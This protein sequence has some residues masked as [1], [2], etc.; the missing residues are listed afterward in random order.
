MTSILTKALL[1]TVEENRVSSAYLLLG[2][3]AQNL[4][5]QALLFA[6]RLNCIQSSICEDCSS[7]KKIE[8]MVHPDV[9]VLTN[10]EESIKIESLRELQRKLQFK[11]YEGKW[12]VVIIENAHALSTPASNCL[13]KVLEEPPQLT[14]FVLL[15]T[16]IEHLLPTIVSRCHIVRLTTASS[17]ATFVPFPEFLNDLLSLPDKV[18]LILDLAKKIAQSDELFSQCIEILTAWYHDLL[19]YKRGITPIQSPLKEKTVLGQ[20]M[21]RKWEL[22]KL[23]DKFQSILEAKKQLKFQVNRELLAESLLLNLSQ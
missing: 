16:H 21:A 18:P 11:P 3:D 20:N 7:C 1:K 5:N 6:K 19:F 12:K 13:L 22:H 4:K 17:I 14:T 23:Y 2:F 10:T 9:M 8:K 15:A